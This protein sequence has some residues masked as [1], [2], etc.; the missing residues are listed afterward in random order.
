MNKKK[1]CSD[2][3]RVYVVRSTAGH[4]VCFSS[5][6]TQTPDQ[7]FRVTQTEAVRAGLLTEDAKRASERSI[8]LAFCRVLAL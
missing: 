8:G 2:I 1:R 7:L 5:Y 4:L 3:I 6:K